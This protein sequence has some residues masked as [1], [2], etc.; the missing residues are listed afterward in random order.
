MTNRRL[1]FHAVDV[2]LLGVLLISTA[3]GVLSQGFAGRATSTAREAAGATR[4]DLPLRPPARASATPT[5]A[6]P[7]AVAVAAATATAIA[8][9]SPA[10]SATVPTT[11]TPRPTR[12]A[13]LTPEARDTLQEPTD[14]YWLS[15]PIPTD[16]T[17]I[18]SRFYP[19]GSTAR[20]QYQT[21]HGVE[22][23]NP[24]GTSVLAAR[25]GQV[26]VAGPDDP[27]VYGLFPDFYGQLVVIKHTQTVHGQPLFTLYGH[28]GEVRAR[29]GQTVEAGDVVGDVGETGIALGPHLHFEVRVGQN[30]YAST[31]NPELWI[32]PFEGYGTIAGRL[33]NADTG[34]LVPGALISLFDAQ[35][36]WEIDAETYSEGANPDDEWRENFVIGDRPA[37]IYTVQYVG[38]DTVVTET[39]TVL[40]GQTALV[41]LK[42]PAPR[43]AAT[44]TA[45]AEP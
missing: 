34:A 12:T 27:D 38:A 37:G 45:T 33:Y 9:T 35:G 2:T 39:V 23:V 18:V 11:R 24:T 25:P 28:L 40:A 36:Q 21:H 41:T 3:F 13:T 8:T 17:N 29:V 1:A 43:P 32:K 14:H 7:T 20:G 10:P 16:A 19:Y 15:R 30:D 22:F 26:V 5:P 42:V 6:R 31:R 4:P 44:A